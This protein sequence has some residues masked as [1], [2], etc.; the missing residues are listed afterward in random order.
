MILKLAIRFPTNFQ[1]HIL[2]FSIIFLKSKVG[3]GEF[4]PSESFRLYLEVE[5]INRLFLYL[6][7]IK[8]LLMEA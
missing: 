1:I 5:A 3:I 2:L 7:E 4:L 8:F 6:F